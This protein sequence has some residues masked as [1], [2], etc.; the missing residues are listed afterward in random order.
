MTYK[1]EIQKSYSDGGDVLAAWALY[2]IVVCGLAG[3]ALAN[4]FA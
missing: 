4:V 3:Y 1:P 2:I